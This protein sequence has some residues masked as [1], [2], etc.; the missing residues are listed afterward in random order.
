MEKINLRTP[1][2]CYGGKQK[3]SA[4]ISYLSA[5][6]MPGLLPSARRFISPKRR[7]KRKSLTIPA[8]NRR[9]FT[10]SWSGIPG[11]AAGDSNQPAQ[12]ENAPPREGNLREP[13]YVR[14]R[15]AGTD[16][17]GWPPTLLTAPCPAAH[18]DTTGEA[19]PAGNL[20]TK[21]RILPLTMPCGLRTRRLSA[22]TPRASFKAGTRRKRFL[23]RPALCRA[24]RGHYDGCTQEDFDRLPDTLSKL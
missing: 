4:V 22:G 1:L 19:S 8:E 23:P 13:G 2:T 9:T 15:R 7:Q 11:L 14:P 17:S 16:I 10:K 6:C 24:V 12:P 5:K 3:P 18:S 20:T 21:N